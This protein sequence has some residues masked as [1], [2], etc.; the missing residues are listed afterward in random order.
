LPRAR[1]KE[2]RR[3]S[4]ARLAPRKLGSLNTRSGALCRTRRCNRVRRIEPGRH[5]QASKSTRSQ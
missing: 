3:S 5:I 2:V 4:P 1:R